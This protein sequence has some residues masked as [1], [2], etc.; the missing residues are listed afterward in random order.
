M[1]QRE[2]RGDLTV[3]LGVWDKVPKG[4]KKTR[5][6]VNEKGSGDWVLQKGGGNA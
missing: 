4:K 5:F 2:R 1:G 3:C 6:Q